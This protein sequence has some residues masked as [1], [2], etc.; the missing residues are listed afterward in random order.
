MEDFINRLNSVP[1]SY[2][3]FVIGI[4]TYVKKNPQRLKIVN[5]FM[6]EHPD[7]NPSDI[8]YF[9]MK[10]PDFHDDGLGLKNVTC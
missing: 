2:F 6:D 1:G 8:V 4:T 9:V 7:A 3:N 10:Q 5:S